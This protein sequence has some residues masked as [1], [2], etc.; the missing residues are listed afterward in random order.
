MSINHLSRSS[1]P[2]NCSTREHCPHSH[3]INL[4]TSSASAA[5][6]LNLII[7]YKLILLS[8]SRPCVTAHTPV[9]PTSCTRS[10]PGPPWMSSLTQSILRW[11]TIP[12]DC[13]PSDLPWD[14]R[15]CKLRQ[16]GASK[17]CQHCRTVNTSVLQCLGTGQH[18]RLHLL[19]HLHPHAR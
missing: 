15:Q 16:D 14:C 6:Q 8:Y 10:P 17:A 2:K 12:A 7:M 4:A 18:P 9:R 1:C 3:G 13:W 11:L 19:L 5:L